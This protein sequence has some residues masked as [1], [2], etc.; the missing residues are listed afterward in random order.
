MSKN[1]A[2]YQSLPYRLIVERFE[3]EDGEVYFRAFYKEIPRVKG[4]HKERLQAIRLAKELFDSYVEA[5]LE[6]GEEIPQP[7]TPRFRKRG[8]L[9][10]FEGD[11]ESRSGVSPAK[12]VRVPPSDSEKKSASSKAGAVQ[13]R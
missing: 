3:E 8:G 7:E 10:K 13:A 11:R 6:W 5:Q 4:I 2:Y 1:L 12:G 9:F